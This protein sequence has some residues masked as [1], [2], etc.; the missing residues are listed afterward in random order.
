MIYI[1]NKSNV[2]NILDKII[3]LCCFLYSLTFLTDIKINFLTTAAAFGLIKLIYVRPNIEINTKFFYLVGLFVICTFLSVI[4]ND[5]S[6]IS[7]ENLSAYKSRFI[8]PLIGILMIFLFKFTEKHILT[9]LAGLSCSL[10]LNAFFVIYQFSQGMT[11]RLVGFAS[12]YMLLCAMNILILPIIFFLALYKSNLPNKLRIFFLTTV[13][14]NIPAVVLENTRIVWIALFIVYLMIILVSLKRKRNAFILIVAMIIC[15][16]VFFYNSPQ[17][18]ERFNSITNV[19]YQNQSNYERLLMW[20]SA[21]NMFIEH[22]FFGVGVGNY[23]EQYM[24]N[25]RSL[26]SREDQWHPHNVPLA[27][28]SETGIVGGISYFLLFIY[29]FYNGI[30]TYRKKKNIA[31]FAYLMCLTAYSINCLTD[32]MFCGHNIKSPTTFFWLFT[33]FYLILNKYISISYDKRI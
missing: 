16:G 7:G 32:S 1:D 18:I 6:S 25:Y 28:L 19:S 23:H 17:S 13:I 31:S 21:G 30:N 27:M 2:I 20:Q 24:N 3:F 22:P 11:G 5:V 29:L 10:L 14:V 4:L 33:G 9:F 12:N 8:S 15:S 26:Y